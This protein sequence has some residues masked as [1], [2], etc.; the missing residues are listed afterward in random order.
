MF[1]QEVNGGRIQSFRIP[2]IVILA[3]LFSSSVYLSEVSPCQ[4]LFIIDK[5]QGLGS[6][7]FF[8]ILRKSHLEHVTC[9]GYTS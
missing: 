2:S 8:L 7:F 5:G 9:S 1:G 4:T 6:F 3:G